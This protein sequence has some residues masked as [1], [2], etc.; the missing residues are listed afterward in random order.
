MTKPRGDS[1]LE[2][3]APGQKAA[4]EE[5]LCEENL[6]Y[7]Q[8]QA[9]LF[10]EFGVR[11]GRKAVTTFYQRC[12]QRRILERIQTSA[13]TANTVVKKFEENPADTFRALMNI[14]GQLAFESALEGKEIEAIGD[15]TNLMLTSRKLDLAAQQVELDRKKFEWNAAKAALKEVEALRAIK[16]DAGLDEDAKLQ[17]VRERLFGETPK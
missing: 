16:A 7:E 10:E 4:L 3:L 13:A 14:V 5:W 8:A 9:R 2:K 12:Q 15:L 17:K 1:K 11:C 6:T